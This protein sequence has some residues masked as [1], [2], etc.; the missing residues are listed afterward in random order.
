M[1]NH[2]QPSNNNFTVVSRLQLINSTL[3]VIVHKSLQPIGLHPFQ[4]VSENPANNTCNET[5]K[6]AKIVLLSQSIIYAN[7]HYPRTTSASLVFASIQVCQY[8]LTF[9]RREQTTQVERVNL[10]TWQSQQTT[11]HTRFSRKA[12]VQMAVEVVSACYLTVS[13]A[14]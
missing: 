2:L 11:R 10:F 12:F 8:S 6:T 13:L 5:A 1:D 4:H 7:I 14:M 9:P 3:F